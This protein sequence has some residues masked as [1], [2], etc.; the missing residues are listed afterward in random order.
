MDLASP[1]QAVVPSLDG[2]V[3][4]ALSGLTTPISGREVARLVGSGSQTGVRRVLARLSLEGTVLAE[5]RRSAVFY[6]ANRDHLA[7]PAVELLAGMRRELLR[8]I[9]EQVGAWTIQ[10][11]TVAV[12]G[13]FARGQGGPESDIDLL[14]VHDNTKNAGQASGWESQV[15]VLVSS[16]QS[17]TGNRAQPYD[18]DLQELAAHVES[19]EPIVQSWRREAIVLVGKDITAL[20]RTVRR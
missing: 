6:V 17:W 8:R 1:H 5:R 12:F 16:V 20:V 19:A 15:D 13:S 11:E 14:L 9:T 4:M 2:A 10:P 7:W 3:L 18:I